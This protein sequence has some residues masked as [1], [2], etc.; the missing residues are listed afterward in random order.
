MRV[1]RV[2]TGTLLVVV[3]LPMLVG[4]GALWGAMRHRAPDGAFSA[5]IAPFATDGYAMVAPDLDGLLRREASFTRGGQTTLSVGGTGRERLFVGI[6]PTADVERYLQGR[7]Q[8]RLT[9]VR[10]AH[11]PLPVD[12]RQVAG[13]AAPAAGPA[14]GPAAPAPVLPGTGLGAALGPPATLPF[15]LAVGHESAGRTVLSWSPSSMRGRDVTL[16]VMNATG[17]PR[18]TAGLTATVYPRWISPMTWAL[19][20][21]G[22]VLFA[23]GSAAL[24]WRRNR[25]IVTWPRPG[26]AAKRRRGASTTPLPVGPTAWSVP[27][28]GPGRPG[29]KP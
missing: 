3:A 2:I 14:A 17:A 13:P 5:P 18:V 6:G 20:I 29:R 11:G 7:P 27:P 12:I 16:V 28:D 15:W 1:V 19:F 10:L 25:D 9:R 23:V 21:L 8:A 4:G 26:S 22:I 24:V